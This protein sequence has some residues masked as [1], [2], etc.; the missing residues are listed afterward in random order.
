D[1]R[2]AGL[3]MAEAGDARA[4]THL[5]A[6]TAEWEVLALLHERE[7]RPAEAARLFAEHER[8]ADAARLYLAAGEAEKSLDVALAAGD[9]ERAREAA[10]RIP[11]ARA[12]AALLSRGQ[13]DLLLHVMAKA[14]RWEDIGKLYEQAGQEAD[15]ARAFEK[16]GR[17]HKA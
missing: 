12:R 5:L 4:A 2:R 3:A 13:G 8:P 15:A 10:V 14:G 6:N 16:A 9:R 17:T 7:G 11:A 1:E